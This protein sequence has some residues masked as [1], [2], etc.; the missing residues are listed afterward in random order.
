MPTD[1]PSGLGD[2]GGSENS[3]PFR[4]TW[5]WPSVDKA[6]YWRLTVPQ[7]TLRVLVVPVPCGAYSAQA[8]IR[9]RENVVVAETGVRILRTASIPLSDGSNR[10][11]SLGCPYTHSGHID[12]A[13]TLLGI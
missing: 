5:A 2:G 9:Y 8:P 4:A 11:L 6:V 10:T 1:H 13:V 7:S 12:S 3:V